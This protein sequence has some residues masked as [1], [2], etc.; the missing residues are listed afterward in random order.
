MS[1]FSFTRNAYDECALE[2]KDNETQSSFKWVTDSQVLGGNEACFMAAAP[3]QQN[4]F[5]SVPMHT[6]DV[7]SDLRGQTRSLS[8]C[9]S[10]KYNP[11]LAKPVDYKVKECTDQRLVSDYTRTNRSCNVLSGVSINRF[12]TLYENPQENISD[13]TL[14]GVNTRLQVK[15]LYKS[16]NSKK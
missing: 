13:N 15:D 3:F 1:H 16:I 11:Q 5:N 4:P 7:E 12:Q 2:Q 8:K 10:F 14:I 6:I 9:D